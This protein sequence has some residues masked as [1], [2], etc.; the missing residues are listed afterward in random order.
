M[1]SVGIKGLDA[2]AVPI[3][4]RMLASAVRSPKARVVCTEMHIYNIHIHSCIGMYT[5]KYYMYIYVSK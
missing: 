1:E 2:E 4:S 3:A 5:H